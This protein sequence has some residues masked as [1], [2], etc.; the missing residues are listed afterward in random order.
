MNTKYMNM[1]ARIQKLLA[2][3]I[4]AVS[5][6]KNLSTNFVEQITTSLTFPIGWGG[7]GVTLVPAPGPMTV[8]IRTTTS[9]NI[10]ITP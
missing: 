10:I 9:H 4:L 1:N 7:V 8:T 6:P 2:I 5:V 3:A